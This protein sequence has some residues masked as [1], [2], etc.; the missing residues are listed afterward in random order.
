MHIDIPIIYCK[1]Y[2][3][4][5]RHDMTYSVLK[6]PLNPNQPTNPSSP[7]KRAVKSLCLCFF[8]NAVTDVLKIKTDQPFEMFVKCM[9]ILFLL[10]I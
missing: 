9:H 3:Q 2:L 6:V 5:Y 1:I 4:T 10:H 7:G 8:T